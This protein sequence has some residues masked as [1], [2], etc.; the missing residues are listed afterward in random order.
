M[1]KITLLLSIMLIA[2]T[3]IFAQQHERGSRNHKGK[4][5][6]YEYSM[7]K[8]LNL[9]TE[10]K[11]KIKDINTKFGQ[12]KKE[13]RK[14]EMAKEMKGEKLKALRQKKNTEIRNILND[15]QKKVWDAKNKNCSVSNKDYCHRKGHHNKNWNRNSKRNGGEWNRSGYL[16]KNIELSEQQKEEYK[17]IKEA[18]RAENEELNKKYFQSRMQ[19]NE[20]QSEAV[21][22][23]LTK[24]QLK[25]FEENQKTLREKRSSA[26]K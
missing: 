6:K 14:S 24:D 10:Q 22:K 5:G 26:R 7:N 23:I 12:E 9:T 2:S 11:E 3:T 25:Q 19:L 16:L 18:Q 4:S 13:I 17:K 21:K 15:D 20:K 1:K 8:D